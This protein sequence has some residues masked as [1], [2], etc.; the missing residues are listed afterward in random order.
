M[1]TLSCLVV[2]DEPLALELMEADVSDPYEVFFDI[3]GI[4]GNAIRINETATVKPVA[5]KRADASQSA[6]VASWAWN[7][8]DNEGNPFTLSGKNAATFDAA[9]VQISYTD[10]KRAKMGISGSVSATIG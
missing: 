2:D 9:S 5:R 3:T 1:I 6:T 10:I 4:T 8:R 7:I